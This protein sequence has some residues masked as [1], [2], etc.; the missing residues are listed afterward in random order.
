[1][2]IVLRL[3]RRE[4]SQEFRT[5]GGNALAWIVMAVYVAGMLYTLVS[6]FIG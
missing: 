1:V 4:A 5:P 3:R 6:R 2:L